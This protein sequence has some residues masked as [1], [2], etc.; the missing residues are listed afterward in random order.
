MTGKQGCIPGGAG[1]A[2]DMQ[3][4][5]LQLWRGTECA[6]ETRHCLCAMHW[7]AECLWDLAHAQRSAARLP[8]RGPQA[9]GCPP[10]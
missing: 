7:S 8:Y 6:A 5:A 3:L 4:E 10:V 9:A 1:A 2:A